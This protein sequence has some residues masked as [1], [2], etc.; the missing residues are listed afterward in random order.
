MKNVDKKFLTQ[1]KLI[2]SLVDENKTLQLQI[3]ELTNE[4]E[5]QENKYAIKCEELNRSL[6]SME[7]YKDEYA[8]SLDEL[9]CLKKQCHKLIQKISELKTDYT[10]E[11][12]KTISSINKGIK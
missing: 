3:Q 2:E 7:K 1:Q 12:K 11:M 4:K 5:K 8:K 10:K 6:L 9:N